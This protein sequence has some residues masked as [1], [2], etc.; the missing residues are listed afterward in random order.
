[1][2]NFN[3]RSFLEIPYDELEEKNLAAKE[4]Q[5]K[6]V[7]P[8][9]IQEEYI[10][11]LHDMKQLKAVTVCFTDLEGKFH[12]L[13]YDKKFLLKSHDNL[14]FD[15]SSVRGF[16]VVRESDLRLAIDWGSFRWLPCDV[17]GP[18]KV[19]VFALIKDR[20][21]K[22]YISDMRHQLQMYLEQIYQKDSR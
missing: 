9:K 13:D 6:R 21:G 15:G 18:G 12:M 11:I 16:S 17:F 7:A 14:T 22:P 4:K 1:M 2:S 19:I 20:D 5:L 10:K 3:L 8:D